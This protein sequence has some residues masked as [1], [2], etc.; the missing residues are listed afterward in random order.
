ME[1]G[2]EG[3]IITFIAGKWA[4]STATLNVSR[5]V[6]STEWRPKSQQAHQII[7]GQNTGKFK[8][9]RNTLTSKFHPLR[10]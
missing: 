5:T 1:R 4:E 3:K 6:S 10:K 7:S 8:F 9:L 2:K